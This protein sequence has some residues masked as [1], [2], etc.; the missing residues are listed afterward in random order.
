M[1][2]WSGLFDGVHG[3]AH[4][5]IVDRP[6]MRGL[7]R[8]LAQKRG[9]FGLMKEAGATVPANRARIDPEL[10]HGGTRTIA[11]EATIAE[12][13]AT[14][15]GDVIDTRENYTYVA[16]KSGNGGEAMS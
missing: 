3:S 15:L 5:L 8:V 14:E 12:A 4:S 7:L 1:A 10:P 2:N 16:D 11:D 6:P 13:T 9:L